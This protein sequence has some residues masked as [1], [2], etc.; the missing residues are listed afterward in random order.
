MTNDRKEF[1]KQEAQRRVNSALVSV[2]PE[3]RRA[4]LAALM[5][6]AREADKRERPVKKTK[7]LQIEHQIAA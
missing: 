7:F 6:F 3:E 1:V 2:R 5:A 4:V